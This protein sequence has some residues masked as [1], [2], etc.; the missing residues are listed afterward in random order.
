MKPFDF[1]ISKSSYLLEKVILG[2]PTLAPMALK[3]ILY[4]TIIMIPKLHFN[5]NNKSIPLPL[6]FETGFTVSLDGQI[7]THVGAHPALDRNQ[8]ENL[9]LAFLFEAYIITDHNSG[10]YGTRMTG[11][12][13]EIE[14]VRKGRS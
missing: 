10:R 6:S 1:I 13:I 5:F 4:S 7:S 14:N 8:T 3:V 9:F 2:K 12:D 11:I